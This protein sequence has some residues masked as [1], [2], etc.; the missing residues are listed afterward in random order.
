MFLDAV[1]TISEIGQ[2]RGGEERTLVAQVG[3]DR[4]VR[5]ELAQTVDVPLDEV[6]MQSRVLQPERSVSKSQH[7][8][9]VQA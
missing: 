3:L 5:E 7:Q 9:P 6:G 2:M 1:S 4:R 8:R